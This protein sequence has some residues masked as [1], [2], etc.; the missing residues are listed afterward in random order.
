MNQ[1]SVST[2]T[3]TQPEIASSA[4]DVEK[5][6]LQF[7]HAQRMQPGPK[8]PLPNNARVSAMP[9]I[10]MQYNAMDFTKLLGD[11]SLILKDPRPGFK[12]VWRKRSDAQTMGWVRAGILR[13]ITLDEVDTSSPLATVVEDI[14][15]AGNFVLWESMALFE[16][17]PKWA[18]KVYQDPENWAIAR[19]AQ[20]A[21]QVRDEFEGKTRGAYTGEFSIKTGKN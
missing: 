6:A 3:P 11:P 18:A 5:N 2:K 14:S 20:Q 10:G 21:Y 17:S 16:M 13:P 7:E 4:A 1:R 15:P 12:Y 9:Y 8:V 19:V